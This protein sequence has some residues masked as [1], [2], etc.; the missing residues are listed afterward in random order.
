M[1]KRTIG[2]IA[3]ALI[4]IL[5]GAGFTR[6]R[7]QT[8]TTTN[9]TEAE[10]V[11]VTTGDLAASI[12]AS[13][14]VLPERQ[15]NLV[16]E[17]PGRVTSIPVTLGQI[18]QAGD[19]LVQLD[20]VALERNLA[21]TQQSLLIQE[22]SLA[23]LLA[24]PSE[25]AL[26]AAEAQL[27]SAQAQLDTLLDGASADEL[28]QAQAALSN[29][30]AN[31]QLSA[32]RYLNSDDT[33]KEANDTLTDAR[34]E[35]D[36][37]LADWDDVDNEPDTDEAEAVDEAQAVYDDALADYNEAVKNIPADSNDVAYFGALT[38][39]IQAELALT[40]L[41]T[42]N[43]QAIPAAEASLAQAQSNL[44][45]LLNGP[46]D[47]RISQV[48]AQ[49]EQAQL[50]V[51]NAQASLDN[52]TLTAPF[53]GVITAIHVAEGEL[54]SG[55]AIQLVD[56]D[57]LEVVLDID[58]VDIGEVIVGQSAEITLEAWP[59]KT[60]IG[61]V[62]SIAPQSTANPTSAIVSYE[63]RLALPANDLTIRS[64][65][66]ANANLITSTRENVLLVPNQAITA[67]RSAG[68]YRVNLVGTDTE[69][70]QTVEEIEVTI[71]LRDGEF[72]EIID[73]LNAGDEL[74]L[75]DFESPTFELDSGPGSGNGPFG[76]N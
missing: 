70:N 10:I 63:V 16:L 15:A 68:T 18:V 2:I 28:A 44:D 4:I 13:G 32:S 66:T 60:L 50:A 56:M 71:G 74:M 29:A 76:G 35:L 45:N 6:A 38:Q 12:S 8:Q 75:G 49:V 1:N 33:L 9:P 59:D 41:T 73:G 67:N 27:A 22:A 3:I 52:A 37:A 48:T 62:V 7:A 39:V 64:G 24:D 69:G 61:E 54:A 34:Q 30:Q 19:T 20:T 55:L 58:E 5:V 23:E 42:P 43:E 57:S 17:T 26:I 31:L 14:K 51:D 46:S 47:E 11:T 72:T 25:Q 53:S 65:M 40:N 21:S 36:N